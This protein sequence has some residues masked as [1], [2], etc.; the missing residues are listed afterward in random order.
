[1]SERRKRL[2][3]IREMVE[4]AVKDLEGGSTGAERTVGSFSVKS[5]WTSTPDL[6]GESS[7]AK[8]GVGWRV[9]DLLAVVQ[10]VTWGGEDCEK[11]FV[12]RDSKDIE[13]EFL[14]KTIGGRDIEPGTIRWKGDFLV[15]P[16]LSQGKKWIPGFADSLDFNRNVDSTEARIQGD[17]NAILKHRIANH[18]GN[19]ANFP[20]IATYLTGHYDKLREREFEGKL[21]TDVGKYW[22]EYHR[23][24]TPLLTS[25]PK[26]VTRRLA[27]DATFA[28]DRVGYLPRD[29]VVALIPRKDLEAFGELERMTGG[30]AEALAYVTDRMN[31]SFDEVLEH[32][33][34]RRQGGFV[35]IDERFL[36]KFYV[37]KPARARGD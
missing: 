15:F 36:E 4:G 28:V 16:Y 6:F 22:Y 25:T 1:M 18:V 10:G 7:I 31:S 35:Q 20:H 37:S 14:Y 24:R 8:S 2:R 19:L 21:I 27:H 34:V 30:T 3:T 32:R 9:T 29:S 33:R 23:P 5:R 12:S 17:W 26:I 11:I 13:Q